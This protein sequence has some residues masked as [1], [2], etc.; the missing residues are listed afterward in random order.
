MNIR[1]VVFV[2]TIVLWGASP[3]LPAP[4]VNFNAQS[5]EGVAP[6]WAWNRVVTIST[7]PKGYWMFVTAESR[8]P[9][10]PL[11]AAFVIQYDK[12]TS[13][14]IEFQG[15]A[16]ITAKDQALW[17]EPKGRQGW[18]FALD[19]YPGEAPSSVNKVPGAV[20]IARYWGKL[21]P[22]HSKFVSE[23]LAISSDQPVR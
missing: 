21:P 18:I 6:V 1:G 12:P 11:E 20:E 22:L 19:Q 5:M 16:R 4:S 3:S 14:R 8:E 15:E 9:G 7:S 23:R 10:K 13:L 17:V 2:A